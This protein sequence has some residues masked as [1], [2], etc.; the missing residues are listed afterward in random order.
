MTNEQSRASVRKRVL[1]R[2]PAELH[3]L[4][5]ER[6]QQRLRSI[7]SEIAV[8]I[9]LG[10]VNQMPESQALTEADDMLGRG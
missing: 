1:V 9:K 3:E 7:N 2:L 6:S 10:L 8:L 5:K 4:I